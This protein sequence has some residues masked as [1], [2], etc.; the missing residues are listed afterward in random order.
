LDE[1][2]PESL[3]PLAHAARSGRVKMGELLLDR[4]AD[5]NGASY[6]AL[7]LAGTI[8]MAEMLLARGATGISGAADRHAE[9]RSMAIFVMLVKR[10][11]KHD[12]EIL[13]D[14][15]AGQVVRSGYAGCRALQTFLG[16]GGNPETACRIAKGRKWPP[17]D[18]ANASVRLPSELRTMR[19]PAMC[20][21]PFAT[22]TRFLVGSTD[23]AS[24]EYSIGCSVIQYVGPR[25]SEY[26]D[27]RAAMKLI[28]TKD[29]R[30]RMA[31]LLLDHGAIIDGRTD[32]AMT[33]LHLAASLG[34]ADMVTFLLSRGAD[35]HIKSK[36][37]LTALEYAEKGGHADCTLILQVTNQRASR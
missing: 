21:T 23:N 1:A 27:G 13:A 6:Q 5:V 34:Q 35:P 33:A 8:E 2:S 9:R 29:M 37:G 25:R 22:F 19:G 18:L 15:L 7:K 26:F 30:V 32:S 4:G 10:G 20:F 36:A 12:K 31:T 14:I 17:V 3:T 24:Y 28:E 11:A 16:A